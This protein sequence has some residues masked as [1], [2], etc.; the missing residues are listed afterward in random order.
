M[1]K[2]LLINAFILLF[3]LNGY[4]Q[5]TYNTGTLGIEVDEYGGI[6]L[7][8]TNGV[9]QLYR[10]AIL[11]GTSPTSVFDYKTDADVESPTVLV[12]NP[13]KSDFEIS[14]AYNN[15]YSG[16]PPDVIVSL[17]AYGWDFGGYVI[18]K[19][20]VMNNEANPMDATAGLDIMSYINETWG[21]DTIDY[22]SDLEV[23]HVHKGNATNM[24]IKLLSTS[25]TSLHSFEWYDG[26][27]VDADY[28]N[29]MH[30]EPLQ[31]FYA[32]NSSDGPITITA[33]HAVTLA[34]GESF[35]LYYAIAL[36]TNEDAMLA[37]IT[38]AEEKYQGLITAIDDNK[39]S[40][41]GLNLGQNHPNPFK[42]STTIG[43]QIPDNGFVSLKVFN[44]MGNE[45]ATLVN[46][47]QTPGSHT[48]QFNANDLSSGIYYCK[49]MF[50][51]QIKST[52]M[53]VIK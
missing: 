33:Q 22:H 2:L 20:N 4:S 17:N 39:L 25:L 52:K 44:T 31:E 16:L 9:Y 50:N 8:D 28:W 37:N 24:G 49:L 3:I 5:A 34:P 21:F 10:A 48:I 51:D 43:Y 7:L 38:E 13:A 47:T 35:N 14:G 15:A 27:E 12:D 26:Y 32:S 30:Y 1:K 29:W 42:Q 19:F 45:V 46:E 18:L 6:G 23:I 36:G 41:Q 53:V 11:V 40:L